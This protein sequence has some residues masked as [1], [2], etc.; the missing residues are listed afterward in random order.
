MHEE[1]SPQAPLMPAVRLGAG[2]QLHQA[3]SAIQLIQAWASSPDVV[4]PTRSAITRARSYVLSI[5]PLTPG[6]P[7]SVMIAPSVKGGVVVTFPFR[8]ERDVTLV[9]LNNR[10]S[11]LVLGKGWTGE[12]QVAEITPEEIAYVRALCRDDAT[13][14]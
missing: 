11:L 5:G 7:S 3:L 13:P 8:G 1:V 4:P 14:L 6:G 10:T 9:A 2:C 12:L